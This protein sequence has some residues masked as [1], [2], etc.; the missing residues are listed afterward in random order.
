MVLLY[1][2]FSQKVRS[3][4]PEALPDKSLSAA[5]AKS[6]KQQCV[7]LHQLKIITD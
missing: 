5:S 7:D 1:P 2:H 3:L 6:Q 4:T